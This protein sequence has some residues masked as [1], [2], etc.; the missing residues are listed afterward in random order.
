MS[1]SPTK[2]EADF[3]CWPTMSQTDPFEHCLW[4]AVRNHILGQIEIN[5]K[6]KM[7][8]PS[9]HNVIH[10]DI[11]KIAETLVYNVVDAAL[12]KY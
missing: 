12:H 5:A 9:K 10:K 4:G 8:S 11:R 6:L 2:K 7:V 3:A 1:M